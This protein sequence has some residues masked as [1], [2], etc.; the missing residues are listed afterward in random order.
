MNTLAIFAKHP[1]PGLVKS[2]LAAA[3]SPEWAARIA[4]AFIRDTADKCAGVGDERVLAY[5]PA[6]ADAHRYFAA[7]AGSAYRLVQQE[8]GDLGQRL[9]AFTRQQFAGGSR[10]LVIIGSDSPSLPTDIVHEAFARLETADVVLGPA[11]DGGYYLIGC[12]RPPPIF[13]GITWSGPRV[14]AETIA[15][16]SADWRLALLPPWYD[17]DTLDDWWTLQGHIAALRR[18]G[19]DPQIPHT[20]ALIK[21]GYANGSA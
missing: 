14:L 9:D 10:R 20:E 3:S 17:V 7:L 5:A 15:R 1:Q 8:V 13:A 11:T 6:D 16:L 21:C 18:V 2:R 12:T 4:D 19:L